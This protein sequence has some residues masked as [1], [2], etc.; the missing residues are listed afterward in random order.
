[1]FLFLIN[2]IKNVMKYYFLSYNTKDN[3]IQM[4]AIATVGCDT[5]PRHATEVLVPKY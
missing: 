5:G 4:L 3:R 1:M 2:F